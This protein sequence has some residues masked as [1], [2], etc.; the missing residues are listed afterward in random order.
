MKLSVCIPSRNRP[1]LV[2]SLI[3]ALDNLATGEHEISYTVGIEPDDVQTAEALRIIQG[4]VKNVNVFFVPETV[5]TIGQIWNFLMERSDAD[6]YMALPDDMTP[7]TRNWDAIIYMEVGLNE[8]TSWKDPD[9]GNMC[10]YPAVSR[11]WVN[12]V[13]YLCAPHF[14]FWFCD[15]WLEET[16]CFAYNK[17]F[18][19]S[20]QLTITGKRGPT[21]NLRE[22]NF[23]W[24]FFN[25]TRLIR[26]KD[27]MRITETQ[28]CLEDIAVSRFS[29]IK[30]FSERDKNYFGGH[31]E[32]LE[33]ARRDP[34][35]P[36]HKY[37]QAKKNAEEY[38]EAN[39]LVLWSCL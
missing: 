36:S 29:W 24:G 4:H 6:I 12:K 19:V 25:A 21:Y 14:P 35:E 10:G 15:T 22:L 8:A 23:W 3:A 2:C 1:H 31:I 37:L 30:K 16:Y 20:N 5:L 33:A 17:P 34:R 27:A 38:L 28:R 18:P 39:A 32:Q 26:I 7:V 13:G 9:L 11:G